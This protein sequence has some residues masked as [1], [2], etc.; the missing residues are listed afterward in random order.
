MLNRRENWQFYQEIK[1][2]LKWQTLMQ[3]HANV[4]VLQLMCSHHFH[5]SKR[6]I[7]W[8]LDEQLCC[9]IILVTV[10]TFQNTTCFVSHTETH[11]GSVME[12]GIV[13][14]PLL[15]FSEASE[16]TWAALQVT[17]THGSFLCCQKASIWEVQG[18]YLNTVVLIS[19]WHSD[20]TEHD[21]LTHSM[22]LDCISVQRAAH[23]GRRRGCNGPVALCTEVSHLNKLPIIRGK[24]VSMISRFF[25]VKCPFWN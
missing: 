25:Y 12:E 7:D 9:W 16:C 17:L 10:G 13:Q 15:S 8:T 5:I 19:L 21:L 24:C 23:Q 14:L 18:F 2:L 6:H 22:S 4:S 3:G 1:H 11:T 20:L